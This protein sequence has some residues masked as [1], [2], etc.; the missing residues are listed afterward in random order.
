MRP[1]NMLGNAVVG[2]LTE[3]QLNIA[4]KRT[5]TREDRAGCKPATVHLSRECSTLRG[6]QAHGWYVRLDGNKVFDGKL[7][8]QIGNLCVRCGA[9]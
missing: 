6:S 4:R 5:G 2:Y 9:R 7:P 3:T 1:S 8:M